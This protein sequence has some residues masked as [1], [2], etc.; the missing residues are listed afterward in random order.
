MKTPVW[1]WYYGDF[2]RYHN[3]KISM[4][5]TQYGCFIP[6]FWKVSDC[7]RCVRFRK[8][9]TLNKPDK[10][11]F[12]SDGKIGIEINGESYKDSVINLKSGTY[13]IIVNVYNPYGIPALYV[14]GKE[15]VS[16]GTWEADIRMTLYGADFIPVGYWTLKDKRKTPT[17]F[18]MPTRKIVPKTLLKNNKEQILDFG[19]EINLKLC[20]GSSEGKQSLK[21]F[22]GESL[23]EVNSDDFCVLT[24][25]IIIDGDNFISEVRGCRYVRIIGKVRDEVYGLCEFMP[26]KK[27]GSFKSDSKLLNKIYSISKYTY[28]LTSNLFFVDGIKRDCWIWGGDAYQSIIFGE[29][30]HL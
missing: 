20:I 5:R 18:C 21:I 8:I 24:D 30:F 16:D 27:I 13:T 3:M 6:A 10:I 14:K 11:L 25:E 2:E 9:V 29:I 22:Y 19:K 26:K 17:N 4:K 15:V 28:E 12:V 1:I 7:N 23:D